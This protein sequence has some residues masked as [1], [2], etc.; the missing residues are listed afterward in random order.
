MDCNNTFGSGG[1]RSYGAELG[2]K[3]EEVFRSETK[4]GV[5]ESWF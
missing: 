2:Y 1:F 4:W 5:V 3:A